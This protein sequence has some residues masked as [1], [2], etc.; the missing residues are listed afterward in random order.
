M[1]QFAFVGKKAV[2]MLLTQLSMINGTDKLHSSFLID[3]PCTCQPWSSLIFTAHRFDGFF[4]QSTVQSASI[5]IFAVEVHDHSAYKYI[6]SKSLCLECDNRCG[7]TK[8][9][10]SFILMF[11]RS[12]FHFSSRMLYIW[13]I[14]I[15]WILL[16][17]SFFYGY[18]FVLTNICRVL[19]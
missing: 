8:S 9:I 12:T 1:F 13:C 3:G 19:T 4:W 18:L 7:I 11:L 17:N 5:H 2:H 16:N 10:S 15:A 6:E 14:C